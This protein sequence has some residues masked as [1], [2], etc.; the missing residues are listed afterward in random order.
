MCILYLTLLRLHL[1]FQGQEAG[2]VAHGGMGRQTV[3]HADDAPISDLVLREVA[4]LADGQLVANS[5]FLGVEMLP[6]EIAR[7]DTGAAP[8]A[9]RQ[10]DIERLLRQPRHEGDNMPCDFFAI[11]EIIIVVGE[12][13]SGAFRNYTPPARPRTPDFKGILT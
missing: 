8:V 12:F 2:E 1:L 9:Q 7:I 11:E 3:R 10:K 4:D 6:V 13:P 5:K